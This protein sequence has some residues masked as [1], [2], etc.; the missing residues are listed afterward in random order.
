[1][2]Y[3]ISFLPA[4]FTDEMASEGTAVSSSS[5]AAA[6]TQHDSRTVEATL[7]YFGGRGRADQIRLA[8]AHLPYTEI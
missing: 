6:G 1:M 3:V 2:N 7:Y 4:L 8:A 5:S